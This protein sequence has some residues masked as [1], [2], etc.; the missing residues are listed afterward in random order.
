MGSSHL[1]RL[2]A[3]SL[4]AGRRRVSD[5]HSQVLNASS[6]ERILRHWGVPCIATRGQV[7]RAR[8][9]IPPCREALLETLT[10]REPGGSEDAFERNLRQLQIRV[11]DPRITIP[12]WRCLQPF[13][14]ESEERSAEITILDRNQV[15]GRSAPASACPEPER[16]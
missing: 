14:P 10:I 12:P 1:S 11:S 9:P 5:T 16:R 4:C 7:N 3:C 15:P 8:R 6:G 13:P 2:K